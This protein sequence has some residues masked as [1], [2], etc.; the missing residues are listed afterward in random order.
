M[1]TDP[2]TQIE[3]GYHNR[4]LV[5]FDAR[6]GNIKSTGIPMTEEKLGWIQKYN[7][8]LTTEQVRHALLSGQSV[9]T[10]FSRFE[11]ES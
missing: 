8:H 6:T 7:G 1:K 10:S 3:L 5:S 2:K 4:T 11:L 9:Y